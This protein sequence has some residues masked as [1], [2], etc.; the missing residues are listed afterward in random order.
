MTWI[1]NLS[2]KKIWFKLED[3][4]PQVKKE[5]YDLEEDIDEISLSEKNIDTEDKIFGQFIKVN[6]TKQKI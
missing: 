1:Y 6:K 2:Q 3:G 4:R 5:A